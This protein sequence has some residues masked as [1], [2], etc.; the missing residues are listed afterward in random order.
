MRWVGTNVGRA[1]Q[2]S[3]SFSLGLLGEAQRGS[4]IDGSSSC[5]VEQGE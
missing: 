1:Q 2:L 4:G 5:S 3:K